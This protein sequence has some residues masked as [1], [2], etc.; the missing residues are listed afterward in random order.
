[1][2]KSASQHFSRAFLLLLSFLSQSDLIY[3]QDCR[4]LVSDRINW[5]KA[6]PGQDEGSHAVGLKMGEV[7]MREA[8][9]DKYPWGYGSYTEGRLGWSGDALQGRLTVL[10][11]DR[12]SSDGKNRFAPDKSDIR[13]VTV[14]LD[15]RVKIV[16]VSWGNATYF[17]EDVKCSQDGFITGKLRANGVSLYS[18]VLRKEVMHPNN[19]GFRNWP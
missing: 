9:P 2:N 19:D 8:H 17:L 15:G 12:K 10:F 16:L 1:M 3:A 7:K 5:I 13:D 18:L 4:T 6:K 11:S 14:F